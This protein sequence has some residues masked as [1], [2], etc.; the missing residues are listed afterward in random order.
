V[1]R[2]FWPLVNIGA[3][4]MKTGA[5]N[6][7]CH[8]VQISQ[9]AQD[10]AKFC[11]TSRLAFSHVPTHPWPHDHRN[12]ESRRLTARFCSQNQEAKKLP[13][14]SSKS[15]ENGSKNNWPKTTTSPQ[16]MPRHWKIV[17]Y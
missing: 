14:V 5:R 9:E 6:R 4:T 1:L 11:K 7:R 16:S 13:E 10:L 2:F 17:C 8:K 15:S 12:I 3:R